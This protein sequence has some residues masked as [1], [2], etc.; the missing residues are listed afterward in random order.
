MYRKGRICASFHHHLPIHLFWFLCS[1]HNHDNCLPKLS[2]IC[3]SCLVVL[4]AMFPKWRPTEG[5]PRLNSPN[6]PAQLS[7]FNEESEW[8]QLCCSHWCYPTA[9]LGL[10]SKKQGVMSY[11]H[12][13]ALP[14]LP[15]SLSSAYHCDQDDSWK[16]LLAECFGKYGSRPGPR[17]LDSNW[18]WG[19]TLY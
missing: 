6:L 4:A 10:C 5:E 7:P 8:K 2:D 16:L 1:T 15:C 13:K 3:R 9:R 19:S 17:S 12:S 14:T 18:K 11:C